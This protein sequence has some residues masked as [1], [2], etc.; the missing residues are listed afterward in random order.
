M[1][2]PIGFTLAPSFRGGGAVW[3]PLVS[4]LWW[5]FKGNEGGGLTL[6]VDPWASSLPLIYDCLLYTSPSPRD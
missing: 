3:L 1:G 5:F 2:E 4:S 6:S